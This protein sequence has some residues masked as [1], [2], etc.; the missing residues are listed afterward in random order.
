MTWCECWLKVQNINVDIPACYEVL[1]LTSGLDG[2]ENNLLSDKRMS[3]VGFNHLKKFQPEL[4]KLPRAKQLINYCSKSY[5]LRACREMVRQLMKEMQTSQL[6][7]F[8]RVPHGFTVFLMV[9]SS[10]LTV[11][12]I[13]SDF[14]SNSQF[15][16]KTNKATQSPVKK[17][18]RHSP[19]HSKNK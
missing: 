12:Q 7:R 14:L 10:F 15:P 9:G 13:L 2:R 6:S 1:W 3:L 19:L 11:S 4:M 8:H 17:I 18:L 5:C 16:K